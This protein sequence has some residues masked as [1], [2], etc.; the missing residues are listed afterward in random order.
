MRLLNTRTINATGANTTATKT[1]FALTVN[2]SRECCANLRNGK[3]DI[4]HAE[5]KS[6]IVGEDEGWIKSATE[7]WGLKDGR[8]N[9]SRQKEG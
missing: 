8:E 3:C 6:V 7:I 4:A 1:M 9:V 2:P 5:R